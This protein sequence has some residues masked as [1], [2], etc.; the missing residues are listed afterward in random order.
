M[1]AQL[2]TKPK[3]LAIVEEVFSGSGWLMFIL[4][5][6]VGCLNIFLVQ[7]Y[8][9]TEEVYQ[10]TL[11]ERLAYDRIEKMLAG[12]REWSWVVYAFV[13]VAV[14]LQIFAISVCLMTG[15]V[16][17][18]RKISYKRLSKM[19]LSVVA[20]VSV[21]RLLPTFVLFVQEIEVLDDLLTSD[22]YSMLALVGR[23]N[24]ASWL[25]VPLAAL[26]AFHLLLLLGFMAG[27]RYLITDKTTQ[28]YA[29]IGYGGGTLLWWVCLMYVQLSFG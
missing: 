28:R 11:G 5:V 6:T 1:V 17:S 25:Q 4:T 15:V 7:E 10:N 2:A 20:V 27:M 16:L 9:L 21:V 23:D 8:I 22:W 12:Q 14:L 3:L 29:L 13:P 18:Y 26:N 24:V 19:V